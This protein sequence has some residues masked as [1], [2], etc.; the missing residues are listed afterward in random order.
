MKLKR[1]WRVALF[2]FSLW[3]R[4]NE[5]G[6]KFLIIQENY[7]IIHVTGT[8]GKG[9]GIAFMSQLF[10]EHK[11]K[12]GTFTSPH[13]VSIYDRICVNHKPISD[14]DLL[15]LGAVFKQWKARNFCVHKPI[16]LF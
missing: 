1:G 5:T 9:S 6:Y 11:K 4:A 16:I 15:E 13:M 7:P 8:N 3:F 2:K 12:V 10:V 14:K